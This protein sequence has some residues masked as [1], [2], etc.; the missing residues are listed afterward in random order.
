MSRREAQESKPQP[1]DV[2]IKELE[3]LLERAQS[4][5]ITP[6]DYETLKVIIETLV[7]LNGELEKKTTSLARLRQLFGI[8]T[9]EK[10][11]DVLG[12]EGQEESN[13]ADSDKDAKS[14]EGD[15]G[16]ES[17]E[18]DEGAEKKNKPKGHGR[19]GADAYTGANRVSV[20][21]P[22]LKPGDACPECEAGKVYKLPK[23]KR[24]CV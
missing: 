19:N 23:P 18:G 8:K 9:S 15:E 5:G 14:D 2:T 6:E 21:H 20:A 1:V 11:R 7:W 4:L 17:D 10:T 16:D 13:K 22:S 3:A 12:K 24:S